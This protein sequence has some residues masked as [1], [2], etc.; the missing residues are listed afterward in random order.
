MSSRQLITL[1]CDT[2][3]DPHTRTAGFGAWFRVDGD[4]SGT[5]FGGQLT[6]RSVSSN[7]AELGGIGN[8]LAQLIKARPEAVQRS[9][10]MIQCDNVYALSVIYTLC[11]GI[12]I[13]N[14][15]DSTATPVQL[16]SRVYTE[17]ELG[18][19]EYIS[20]I[21]QQ[22]RIAIILRHVKGHAKLKGARTWVNKRCD[23][24]AKRHALA[25][26][27]NYRGKVYASD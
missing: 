5:T 13:S 14:H 15:P 20:T 16:R 23:Q 4:A 24:I 18:V 19:C 1:F 2:S 9:A 8:A 6:H 11:E 22:H 12:E 7:E 3:F 17:F 10:I 27:A 26:I 21:Q 25:A